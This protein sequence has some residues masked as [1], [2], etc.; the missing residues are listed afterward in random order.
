MKMGEMRTSEGSRKKK[1]RVGR[2]SSSG[3]GKTSGRGNKGQNARQGGGVRPGFEG[4]Q[5][6]LYRRLPKEKGFKNL[7][8]KKYYEIMNVGELNSYKDVVNKKVLV[9]AGRIKEGELLK[10]LGDG[11]LNVPLTIEADRFTEGA[12]KK[13][14]AAGGKAVLISK[15]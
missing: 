10:I 15:Q 3:H 7:L 8:F 14:K 5:T 11:D 9:E 12:M 4:G 1:K 6:P 13:I 2:G